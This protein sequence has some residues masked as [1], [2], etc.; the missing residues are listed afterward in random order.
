VFIDDFVKI[1]VQLATN[2]DNELINIGAGEE[3]TI[4]HFAKL[5][6]EKV[7]YDFNAIKFDTSRYVGA[8]SKCLEISKLNK[9]IS[10]LT[11]TPLEL[12]LGKT[13]EWFWEEQEQ[14]LPANK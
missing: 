7:G 13:I 12:G 10:N 11:L 6:C 5:I 2:L 3:F 8:K 1:T 9:Y 14:L 4:R